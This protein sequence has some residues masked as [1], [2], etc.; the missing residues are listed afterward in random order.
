MMH[1]YFSHMSI[2]LKKTR[3]EEINWEHERMNDMTS[4][5]PN[6]DIMLHAT[7]LI[8]HCILMINDV[9]RPCILLLSRC[10]LCLRPLT[11]KYKQCLCRCIFTC[12]QNQL[13]PHARAFCLFDVVWLLLGYP[14][15]KT[16][17]WCIFPQS[18]TCI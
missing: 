9:H 18:I 15:T 5:N 7:L 11:T 10:L 1:S 13:S 12:L 4:A 3:F 14:Q 8:W 17:K 6:P 16:Q 2:K